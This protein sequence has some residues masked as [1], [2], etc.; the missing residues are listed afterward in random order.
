MVYNRPRVR[1]GLEFKLAD[2]WRGAF[3]K[4]KDGVFHIWICRV[5]CFPLHIRI[6]FK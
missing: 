6:L 4:Y 1:I 5:P 2:M 3:F